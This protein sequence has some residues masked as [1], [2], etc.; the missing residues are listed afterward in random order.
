[1]F[2][3]APWMAEFLREPRLTDVVRWLSLTCVFNAA[4]STASNLL[5]R[6]LR[7]KEQAV[8]QM[9]SYAAAYGLL[10]LPM[11][12][13]GYG[14]WSLVA[15]WIF[16]ALLGAVLSYRSQ[17]HPWHPLFRVAQP[18][19]FV[20]VGAVVFVTNIC[21][22]LLTNMD[23]LLIGRLPPACMPWVTTWPVC[24]TGC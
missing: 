13:L 8:V 15:A 22:W 1:M 10:G 24:Q 12:A 16:Q 9:Q 20:N 2:I 23:R 18:R 7:F 4:A 19:E 3:G 6:E 5:R 14:V 11:A 21:N 17:A